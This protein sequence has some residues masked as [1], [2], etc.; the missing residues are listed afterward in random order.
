MWK[1]KNIAK[2]SRKFS[3]TQ[4]P[5]SFV[6]YEEPAATTGGKPYSPMT[7]RVARSK[8]VENRREI[9]EE[10]QDM[11]IAIHRRREKRGERRE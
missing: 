7:R 2:T 11:R 3:S 8:D 6:E 10:R 4:R 5:R 1:H 9:S